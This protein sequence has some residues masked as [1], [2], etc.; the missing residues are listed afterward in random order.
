MNAE[1]GEAIPHFAEL[2]AR[3]SASQVAALYV[4][5]LVRLDNETRYVVALQGLTQPDGSPIEAPAGFRFVRDGVATTSTVLDE[6]GG[7]VW[8]G[9]Q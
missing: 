7:V 6:L 3:P 2:D 1:T 9:A 8:R 5:P 4:R